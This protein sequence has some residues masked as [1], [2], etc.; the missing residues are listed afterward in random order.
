MGIRHL[1]EDQQREDSVEVELI[2]TL[3]MGYTD[4]QLPAMK[5][6][7]KVYQFADM[8]SA[9]DAVIMLQRVVSA[10]KRRRGH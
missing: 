5:I 2:G 8:E 7:G 10:A 6:N 3:M 9:E 1:E 4:Q